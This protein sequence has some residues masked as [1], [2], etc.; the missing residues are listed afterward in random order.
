MSTSIEKE[1]EVTWLEES[2]KIS[3]SAH[4]FPPKA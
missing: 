3:L 4:P 1:G 2:G